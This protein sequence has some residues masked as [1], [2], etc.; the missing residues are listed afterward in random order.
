LLKEAYFKKTSIAFSANSC[1]CPTKPIEGFADDN[2]VFADLNKG[3]KK[4]E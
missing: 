3:K 1:L 4:N 2:W